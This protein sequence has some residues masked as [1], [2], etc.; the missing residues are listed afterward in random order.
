MKI[1]FLGTGTSQGVPVI[2]CECEVCKSTD[3]KDKRLRSSVMVECQGN[4]FVIDTGPDFRAQMLRENVKHLD[5]VI[6]THAHKD[7]IA[8]LDDV[9]AFNYFQKKAIDVYARQ[10]VNIQIKNEFSYAF[11]V[12]KYPG[13][14]EINLHT[15]ENKAF[16]INNIRIIPI[17][18][19]H[20]GLSIFGFR[21]G[22]F[23]YITD[24]NHI[25][26]KEIEKIKGSKVVVLNALRKKKHVSHFNLEEA[27]DILKEI[28]AEHSYLTHISHMMGLHEKV[29]KELPANIKIAYDGLY[30]EI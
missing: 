24:A 20:L 21:I 26:N 2:A 15:I 10:D 23:T 11:D 8:G 7:H 19:S 28:N 22:D 9:R 29:E 30:L 5:A 3:S 13:V 12:F 25:S 1:T 27:V 16:E 4:V 17:E 6:L 18:V 14:P